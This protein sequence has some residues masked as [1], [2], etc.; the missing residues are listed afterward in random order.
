MPDDLDGCELDFTDPA[1]LTEDDDQALALV[2]FADIWDDP[3][4]VAVRRIR[5]IEWDAATRGGA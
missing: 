4:A 1:H 3:L 2:L 5:L